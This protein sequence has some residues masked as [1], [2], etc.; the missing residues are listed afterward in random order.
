MPES[1]GL[2]G[3]TLKQLRVYPLY[4]SWLFKKTNKPWLHFYD[5]VGGNMSTC[6]HI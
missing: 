6:S 3:L 1:I 5:T 2:T 4:F